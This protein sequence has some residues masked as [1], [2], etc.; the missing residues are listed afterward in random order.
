MCLCQSI[1]LQPVLTFSYGLKVSWHAV[2]FINSFSMFT[3]GNVWE[4]DESGCRKHHETLS[5]EYAR[6][7]NSFND[8]KGKKQLK[9]YFNAKRDIKSWTVGPSLDATHCVV[10]AAVD[11]TKEI[12][13]SKGIFNFMTFSGWRNVLCC[14]FYAC[15]LL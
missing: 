14:C 1:Y 15:A 12:F 2:F 13:V 10:S 4:R 11:S 6:S 3:F 5:F 8:E 9:E 7:F